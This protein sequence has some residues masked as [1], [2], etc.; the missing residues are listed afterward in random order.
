MPPAG[1]VGEVTT[2][3]SANGK[4]PTTIEPVGRGAP[5]GTIQRADVAAPTGPH[6]AA[7]TRATISS[8]VLRSAEPDRS[9]IAMPTL[10]GADETPGRPVALLNV[11]GTEQ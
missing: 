1:A 7:T 8:A 2:S 5:A 3:A 10:P 11:I 6:R 9:G 4:E